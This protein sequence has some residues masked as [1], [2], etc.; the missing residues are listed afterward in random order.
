M[1]SYGQ[2]F[3]QHWPELRIGLLILSTEKKSLN[4]RIAMKQSITSPFFQ[5]WLLKGKHDLVS[6]KDVIVTRDFS[7]FGEIVESNSLAMHAVI[8]TAWPPINYALPKT[9][10]LIQT[11]WSLRKTG[12]E[13]YFTQDAGPNLVLLFLEHD[14]KKVQALF[15]NVQ[16]IDPF[17]KRSL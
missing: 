1:D 14:I 13:I 2:P 7:A 10:E 11:I 5:R 4:S 16:I 6:L 17:S 9:V 3:P 15:P 12:L 8:Q